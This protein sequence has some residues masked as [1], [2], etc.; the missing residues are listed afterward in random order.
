MIEETMK[1]E[2]ASSPLNVAQTVSQH[3][4]HTVSDD[5]QAS[6]TKDNKSLKRKRIRTRNV[7]SSKQQKV[8]YY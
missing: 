3:V 5:M 4:E 8:L 2:A 6:V 7:P 1:N